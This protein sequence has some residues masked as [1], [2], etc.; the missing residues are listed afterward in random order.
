MHSTPL[1][2]K[3]EGDHSPSFQSFTSEFKNKE[4]FL[5]ALGMT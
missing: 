3:G 1:G 5:A 4:R 2:I